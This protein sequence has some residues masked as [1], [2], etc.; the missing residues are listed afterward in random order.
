MAHRRSKFLGITLAIICL[1]GCASPTYLSKSFDPEKVDRVVVLPF[2]D[3]RANPD[4]KHDF[5]M[6][7]G[8]A[9]AVAI[10]QLKFEKRYRTE[11][12]SDI[13]NVSGY[14]INDLPG[15][16]KNSKDKDSV[17][18]KSVDPEWV[19]GLGPV[20]AQWVLV[21]V[22]DEVGCLNTLVQQWGH[23][24]VTMYLF[25]KSAG[26]LVWKEVE[27]VRLASG[28]L[29]TLTAGAMGGRKFAHERESLEIASME[30]LKTLPKRTGPQILRE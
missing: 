9:E 27:S 14:S 13:G 8:D 26:A 12:T 15:K 7:C 17:D 22:L 4:P 11:S 18:P 23:A 1:G 24:K 3:N 2:M 29:V 21:P 19:K 16:D 5:K 28:F 6:F 10:K 25:D 30:C 20:S